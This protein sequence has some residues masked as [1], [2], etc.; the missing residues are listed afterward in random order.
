MRCGAG[1]Q[2][3]PPFSNHGGPTVPL[4]VRSSAAAL[5]SSV[6]GS[7]CKLLSGSAAVGH[8]AQHVA[9][10]IIT[11]ELTQAGLRPFCRQEMAA[12]S[13]QASCLSGAVGSRR[14]PVLTLLTTTVPE[15]RDHFQQSCLSQARSSSQQSLQSL[16][17][18]RGERVRTRSSQTN[19]GNDSSTQERSI[20]LNERLSA[21]RG[22]Q[23]VVIMLKHT[24][25]LIHTVFSGI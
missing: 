19:G 9:P 23:R 18:P 21:Y 3:Q 16:K 2:E 7:H 11:A 20:S 1:L 24:L 13:T 8:P 17:P 25:L 4:C 10:M 15:E 5:S 14:P 22:I 6:E 12:R